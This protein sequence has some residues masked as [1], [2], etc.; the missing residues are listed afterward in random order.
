MNKTE[1]P[2]D[3]VVDYREDQADGVIATMYG[4]AVPYDTPTTI[5]G[6]EESFAPGA[7]DP[8]GVI[9]KP[10]A[11]R[12]DAPVGVITDASTRRTGYTLR[13]TFLTPSKGATPL[14]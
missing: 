1:T 8:A 14:P 3:L 13:P 5:S 10:L 2:F 12:H 6:V 9:G 7:F 4:R 11:W